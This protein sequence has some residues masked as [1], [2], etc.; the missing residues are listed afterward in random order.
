MSKANNLSDFLTDI[1]DALRYVKEDSNMRNPQ[2]FSSEIRGLK[3]TDIVVDLTSE[4]TISGDNLDKV[5]LKQACLSQAINNTTI[6]GEEIYK[7]T[8]QKNTSNATVLDTL[9][10]SEEGDSGGYYYIL[11]G[12]DNYLEKIWV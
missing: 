6:N 1:A 9:F 10:Y 11:S 2:D 5:S 7:I 8:V 12:I 4:S 3:L